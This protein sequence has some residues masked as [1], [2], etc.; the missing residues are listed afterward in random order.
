[1]V[2]LALLGETHLAVLLSLAF[3]LIGMA[4]AG[5]I[6]A[7]TGEA[8]SAETL[9]TNLCDASNQPGL[10][11]RLALPAPRLFPPSKC[12]AYASCASSHT[13]VDALDQLMKM[14][15]SAENLDHLE[16]ALSR[17]GAIN[18]GWDYEPGTVVTAQMN[19]QYVAAVKLLE[20]EVFVQQFRKELLDDPR[21]LDL[22]ARI[23]PQ[24]DP[25][26]DALGAARRHTV[27]A[28]ATMKDG[29][30]LEAYVE[31]RKG[32]A[33]RP[34]DPDEIIAKFHSVAAAASF[35]DSARLHAD[36]MEV[37]ITPDAAALLCGP[38]IGPTGQP[39]R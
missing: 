35:V 12:C 9:G 21:L 27:R 6:M 22:V 19:A 36:I 3:G 20:G 23:S 32:S 37:D 14:G 26:I 2:S 31:Q 1:M 25:G 28:R 4:P 7:L 34:L 10:F 5:V 11:E 29:T 38:F 24:H 16:L 8:M 15:L 33:E 30:V 18:V 39:P 17:K 13:T